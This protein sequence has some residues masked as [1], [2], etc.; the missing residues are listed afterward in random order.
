M[1]YAIN[2][3]HIFWLASLIHWPP[4]HQNALKINMLGSTIMPNEKFKAETQGQN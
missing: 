1:Q 3:K 4:D 2:V